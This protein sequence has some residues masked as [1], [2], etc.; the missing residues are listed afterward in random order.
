M[1]NKIARVVELESF[2]QGK[3]EASLCRVEVDGSGF[4]VSLEGVGYDD[5]WG[6]GA[7]LSLYFFLMAL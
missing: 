3:S 1:I 5:K 6:T 4:E 7:T 2:F